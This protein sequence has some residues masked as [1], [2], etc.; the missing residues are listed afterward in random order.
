MNMG[1]EQVEGRTGFGEK[2]KKVA[3]LGGSLGVRKDRKWMYFGEPGA[4]SK[5][6][7]FGMKGPLHFFGHKEEIAVEALHSDTKKDLVRELMEQGGLTRR[8]AERTVDDMIR[9][10]VLSEV[11][12]PD[13]GKVL[14]FRGG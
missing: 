2:L 11:D 1:E 13:L 12:D 3:T 10:G 6:R 7:L 4:L 9:K 5:E 8:E 14:V